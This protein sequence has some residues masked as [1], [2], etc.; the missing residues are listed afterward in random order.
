MSVREVVD[1][2]LRLLPEL[3]KGA[4]GSLV[5][6]SVGLTIPQEPPRVILLIFNINY[7]LA[8]VVRAVK[9]RAR[10]ESSS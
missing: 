5:W 7:D 9:V 2:V 3:N 1:W 10:M 4:F 6:T 8:M